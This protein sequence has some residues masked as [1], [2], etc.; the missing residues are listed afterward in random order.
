MGHGGTCIYVH[1]DVNFHDLQQADYI[2]E[3]HF[4]YSAVEIKSLNLIILC[5]YRPPDGNLDVFCE[6]LDCVLQNLRNKVIKNNVIICGDFNVHYIPRNARDIK[7]TAKLDLLLKTFGLTHTVKQPTRKQYLIDNIYVNKQENYS[8]EVIK[9]ALSDHNGIFL[10]DDQINISNKHFIYK[11]IY[12][13]IK[14]QELNDKLSQQDWSQVY[15][16]ELVNVAFEF[17]H[18]TLCK[19]I[20]STFPLT[21]IDINKHRLNNWITKGIRTSCKTKR[22]KF[23]MYK[24][25]DITKED[26]MKYANILKHV[27]KRAKKLEHERQII[28]SNNKTKTI[29]NTINQYKGKVKQS[30]SFTES[31]G[32]GRDKLLTLNKANHSFLNVCPNLPEA[33]SNTQK[34]K[35]N[36]RSMF[37]LPTTETEVK[38]TILSMKNTRSEGWDEVS[39]NVLKKNADVL[40]TVL[41]Y[42]INRSLEEGI[43]PD[44]LK[45]ADVQP[46]YKKGDPENI[47]NYRP[48]AILSNISKI[49]E[50]II[51]NRLDTF[52]EKHQ[53]ITKAQ[54]GFRKNRTTIRTV[55]QTLINIFNSFNDNH[56]TIGIFL[57]LSKAFDSIR[58][59]ILL[60]KL[61]KYGVRGVALQLF[62]SYLTDRK[63]CLTEL[64]LITGRKLKSEYANI[65]KGVPQGSILGPLLYIIYTNDLP[66]WIENDKVQLKMYADDTSLV[67]RDINDL[68]IQRTIRDT[69]H[70]LDEWFSMNNLKLNMQKTEI[71]DFSS[72]PKPSRCYMITNRHGINSKSS[73]RFL[74]LE[75]DSELNWKEHT[76]KI[77]A[78][79]SKCA[80]LLRNL[81]YLVS[82]AAALT[83][84]HALAES[85]MRYGVMLWGAS[86]ESDEVF[87]MQKRCIRSIFNMKRTDSCRQIFSQHKIPTFYAIYILEC[88]TFVQENQDLFED[89]KKKHNYQVRY[90]DDLNLPAYKLTRLQRNATFAVIKIYNKIPN[91]LRKLPHVLLKKKLKSFLSARPIYSLQEYM[92]IDLS[93]LIL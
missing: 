83:A 2:I 39:V 22:N 11:R 67:F 38:S 12:S 21:K 25:G 13:D 72:R 4:E 81:A 44:L 78:K 92:D 28:R 70:R 84:Y 19:L 29:W 24:N 57:D 71:I 75:V 82:Q 55:Y 69:I 14:L 41:C 16:E 26:Y 1:R 74:G 27:I 10:S 42:L 31:I 36:T 17:F 63:Q 65:M 49:F 23:L 33:I 54:N 45:I 93:P 88:I 50:K 76:A 61:E 68:R 59:D 5:V 15:E 46:V 34:I 43:F 6:K 89:H 9:T 3:A 62:K 7:E 20:K 58:Y 40:S 85:Q 48:V 79:L 77:T 8:V 52:L 73:S 91:E 47:E 80:Y 60:N 35:V 56:T 37:L 32:K 66:E 51:Y 18:T 30:T 87:L 86:V 90:K 64:D 53:L